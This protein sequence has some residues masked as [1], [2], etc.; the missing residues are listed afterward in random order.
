MKVG[1]I[2]VP[3]ADMTFLED[4]NG[5]WEYLYVPVADMTFLEDS[6]GSWDY[7]CSSV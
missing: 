7:L 2:Y 3:V 1:T 5:S 4:S 6:N